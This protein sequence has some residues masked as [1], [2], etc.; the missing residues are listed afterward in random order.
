MVRNVISYLQSSAEKFPERTAVS[1]SKNSLNY[2]ELWCAV[3][4]MGSAIHKK[5]G[6]TGK[7][8]AVFIRH[9]LS[10]ILAFFSI[11][12]SGNFYVPVDMS[13][14]SERTAKIFEIIRPAA[15]ISVDGEIPVPDASVPLWTQEELLSLSAPAVSP[16]ET[17]K[18]TDLLYVIFTSGS[19]GEPKGVAI[20]HRSVIDMVEEFMAAFSFDDGTVFGNQAP[21]DFD[22]SVK[23]IFLSLKV[24]GRLEILE[25]EL[26]SL[27]KFL[28]ER[29]NERKV[30][31]I[32]WAV[33]ALNIIAQ[34]KAFRTHFPEHLKNVMFSG[35]IM[36]LKTL[37]YWM[38]ALPY[39]RFVNLY[40]PTEITCNCTYH[41]VSDKDDLD[42]ALP[43]GVPFGNC[44]VFLLEDGKLVEED[45]HVGEICV[46]GSC[47]AMGYYRRPEITAAA[48]P[49]NPANSEYPERIYRTGDLGYR[50]DGLLF[51]AGRA[52]SQIKHMGHRIE[53]T[54]IILCANSLDGIEKS[55]ALYDK[56]AAKIIL[57]YEG[58]ASDKEIYLYLRKRLPRYMLPNIIKHIDA[59]PKTR[60]G[61]ID[62]KALMQLLK[63]EKNG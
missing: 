16:W 3:S 33:P 13:L 39:A 23:D 29:L 44:S 15:V 31:T 51:F 54:E 17:R 25:K 58:E 48:F 28:I 40:G 26:F 46:S 41:V 36:P 62:N 57:F 7:P 19:T 21:F 38:E 34:L 55:S 30:D 45:E 22:V 53:L 4:S 24:G 12:F 27:P 56:D 32:I 18:D 9:D 37:Q 35:E 6:C 43:I 2:K 1:D 5:L 11:A 59:F 52:D 63:G 49:Q 10:D 14:P 61:K 8:V 42:A 47:L 20:S 50:K 60:T